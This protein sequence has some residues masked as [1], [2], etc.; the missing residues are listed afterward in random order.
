MRK[1]PDKRVVIAFL[2][3]SLKFNLIE[4]N[5]RKIIFL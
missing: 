1:E 5:L 3:G 2:F 4:Y